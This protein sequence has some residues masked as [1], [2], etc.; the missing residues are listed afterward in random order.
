MWLDSLSCA[1]YRT[2]RYL[3]GIHAYAEHLA[4]EC[5]NGKQN[6]N[7]ESGETA[8]G[9]NHCC[10]ARHMMQICAQGFKF[11]D[12]LGK[13]SI[14]TGFGGSN[15]GVNDFHAI[16]CATAATA[17]QGGRELAC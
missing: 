13:L 10:S 4:A 16:K 17:L 6:R 2:V 11:P 1:L 12:H 7:R 3:L 15:F 14:C 8:H 9:A 5:R